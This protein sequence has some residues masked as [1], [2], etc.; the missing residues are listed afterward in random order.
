MDAGRNFYNS[1]GSEK[2]A[3]APGTPPAAPETKTPVASA[4]ELAKVDT[5]KMTTEAEKFDHFKQLIE[6]GGG[7]FNSEPG[8]RNIVSVRN[9]DSVDTGRY[10]EMGTYN[11]KI[12]VVWTDADGTKHV[13]EFEGNV[14]P[15]R[16]WANKDS[17][18]VNDD[19]K[20]DAGRLLP[21]FYKYEVSQRT[22][23]DKTEDALRPVNDVMVTR[24]ESGWSIQ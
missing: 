2:V 5:S 21:G 22:V 3:I 11:D 12:A 19:G 14:D 15:N 13:K 24:Y 1:F 8:A 17:Q 4:Q 23:N 16:Y 18:D 20:K 7:K 9:Q 6:A 10:N